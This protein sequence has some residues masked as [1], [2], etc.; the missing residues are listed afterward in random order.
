MKDRKGS[1]EVE[2]VK[3]KVDVTRWEKI[4]SEKILVSAK[5]EEREVI[6]WKNVRK[7]MKKEKKGVIKLELKNGKDGRKW[8]KE[9]EIM[10]KEGW[11]KMKTYTEE[12]L[13]R[14]VISSSRIKKKR[15]RERAKREASK[16]IKERTG[17]TVVKRVV[18]RVQA[19]D[20]TNMR[21]M[22]RVVKEM[23]RGIG[24]SARG[25]RYLQRRV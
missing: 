22:G 24:V 14:V 1:A 6:G 20:R 3:G 12:E 7:E 10:S 13:W 21:E 11:D 23:I 18:I 2:W 9:I 19:N 8:V 4:W 15:V 17:V 16:I 5:I 25:V